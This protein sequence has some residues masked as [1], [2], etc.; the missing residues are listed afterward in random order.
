MYEMSSACLAFIAMLW[1]C[2]LFVQTNDWQTN[3][4]LIVPACWNSQ[5]RHIFLPRTKRSMLLGSITRAWRT[6][7]LPWKSAIYLSSF[8]HS[9]TGAQQSISLHITSSSSNYSLYNRYKQEESVRIRVTSSR[10]GNLASNLCSAL[11]WKLTWQRL[12]QW[13]TGKPT[14][15]QPLICAGNLPFAGWCNVDLLCLFTGSL[16]IMLM[17]LLKL[18]CT[19]HVLCM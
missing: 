13:W 16:V 12:R 14:G 10:R 2:K 17:R 8:L 6:S 11:W 1:C 9:V 3:A 19:H 4:R 15:R 7:R 5:T 18:H